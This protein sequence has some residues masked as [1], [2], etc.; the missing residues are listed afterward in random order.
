MLHSGGYSIR[1][2][3]S[4]SI[5]S[6]LAKTAAILTG[7]TF[8]LVLVSNAMGSFFP[9]VEIAYQTGS[10][11][12][13]V[14]L[15][16]VTRAMRHDLF[17]AGTSRMISM[18]W[19]PDGDW[20]AL[21]GRREQ[22]S[23]EVY[24]LSADGRTIRNISQSEAMDFAPTWLDAQTIAFWTNR[25]NGNRTVYAVN[26]NHP[27]DSLQV[28]MGPLT[29]NADSSYAW[30]PDS[31]HYAMVSFRHG[32]GEIYMRDI[33]ATQSQR[34]TETA[35]TIFDNA[36]AWSPDGE[37]IAFWSDRDGAMRL[38]VMNADGSDLQPI[39]DPFPTPRDSAWSIAW[40]PDGEMLA[41][42]ANFEGDYAIYI[43]RPDG[44]E[45]RRV[46][47]LDTHSEPIT[48]TSLAWRPR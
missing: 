33:H 16:D 18:E 1:S 10:I 27:S 17:D 2:S 31:Q 13:T 23:E 32:E 12:K 30:S 4:R 9:S 19:S 35:E 5:L 29:P 14:W 24:I 15:L 3:S 34:L 47:Y 44:T 20:L 48:L 39:R 7:I 45:L 40:S 6:L 28:I 26:V 11:H 25:D 21:A 46:R 8:L 38:Y 37:H 41:F 22:E 36:P 42:T 43:M